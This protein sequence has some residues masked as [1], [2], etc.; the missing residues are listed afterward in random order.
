MRGTDPSTKPC[1][2]SD[3]IGASL[4]ASPLDEMALPLTPDP[5]PEGEGKASTSGHRPGGLRRHAAY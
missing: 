2:F 3:A 5:S 4:P 1:S